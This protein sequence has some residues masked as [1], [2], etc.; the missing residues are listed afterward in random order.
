MINAA[1]LRAFLVNSNDLLLVS[2]NSR[3]HPR[4]PSTAIVSS[5]LRLVGS[6]IFAILPVKFFPVIF[7]IFSLRGFGLFWI[8]SSP[9][10]RSLDIHILASDIKFIAI[11]LANY[12]LAFATTTTIGDSES[13]VRWVF[14]TRRT[15][16]LTMTISQSN[17]PSFTNGGS[18]HLL[19]T[20]APACRKQREDLRLPADIAPLP[21]SACCH[22]RSPQPYFSPAHD[23]LPASYLPAHQSEP[24]MRWCS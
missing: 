24:T 4:G 17:L 10:C 1:P 11:S 18:L 9:L 5:V 16:V 21:C 7:A 22:C 12:F 23:A 6:G 15:V 3:L 20:R 19:V 2:R 14:L 13:A 8:L